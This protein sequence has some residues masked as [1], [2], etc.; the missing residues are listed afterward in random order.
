MVVQRQNNSLHGQVS[1][2]LNKQ[3]IKY[4]DYIKKVLS[5]KWLYD[6]Y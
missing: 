3:A 4:P 6:H 2:N 1:L 5:V